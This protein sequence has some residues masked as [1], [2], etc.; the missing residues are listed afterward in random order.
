M[1]VEGDSI[2]PHRDSKI[3]ATARR[4]NSL[5][6]IHHSKTGFGFDRIPIP[7]KAKMLDGTK[8]RKRMNGVVL[9]LLQI[10]RICTDEI[11]SINLPR[12]RAYVQ[13]RYGHKT[14]QMSY[15]T[16]YT[17]G[18]VEMYRRPRHKDLSGSPEILP[19]VI[20]Q[21]TGRCIPVLPARIQVAPSHVKGFPSIFS[22]ELAPVEKKTPKVPQETHRMKQGTA[23]YP[24]PEQK[25]SPPHF[26]SQSFPK[27]L[28]TGR[29]PAPN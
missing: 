10:G 2:L 18:N 12:K 7:A 6:R 26:S 1:S 24:R 11:Q 8:R 27:H 28:N 21:R 16:V 4:Q 19:K 17:R 25:Q 29:L 13:H 22:I 14:K 9:N 15:K 3:K 23:P 20:T 5:H